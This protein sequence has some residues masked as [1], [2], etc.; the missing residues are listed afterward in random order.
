M[1]GIDTRPEPEWARAAAS[2]VALI[3]G[4][5]R[6]SGYMVAWAA[7]G[8]VLLCF[9]T[10]YLRYVMGQGLIW[11]QESY[12][13]THVAVIVLGAGYT[14]MSGGF[15]RVDVLYTTWDDRKRA[16]SDLVMTLLLL[17]P[18]LLVFGGAVWTFW[19]TSYAS[20]E[21]SLN[22]GGM[23]NYWIL[24]AM[25]LGFVLLVALQGAAFVLRAVL[26]LAGYPAHALRH[27][28]HGPD[29]SP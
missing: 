10:V 14:M 19:A 4:I 11:L 1:D 18:F 17:V 2:T 12:I 8:T 26:V 7:L 15:V 21:G 9:A 13:W 23:G 25:L 5:C 16:I 27:A 24:K 20:D 6:W 28:G 22:P 3:D 29:Q